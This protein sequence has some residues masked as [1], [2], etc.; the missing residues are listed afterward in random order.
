MI[1]AGDFI[2]PHDTTVILRNPVN[3]IIARN[4]VIAGQLVSHGDLSIICD[5]IRGGS[6]QVACYPVCE[7]APGQSNGSDPKPETPDKAPNGANAWSDVNH[8]FAAGN[9]AHGLLGQTG[10]DGG[11]GG[12]GCDG[13]T[14]TISVGILG[15]NLHY[16]VPGGDGGDGG[17]AGNGGGG[18]YGGDGGAGYGLMTGGNGGHGSVG[19]DGGF[20]GRGENPATAE[21]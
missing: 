13:A 19:G 16:L 9:G 2:V 3:R 12:R 8:L 14:L 4:V 17:H 15:P 11:T 6:G 1:E 5:E 20:G 7:G 18:G 10:H 21:S